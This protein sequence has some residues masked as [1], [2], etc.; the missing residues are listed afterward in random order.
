MQP[1]GQSSGDTATKLGLRAG[2]Y[3]QEIGY[4]EDVDFDLR[5]AI[6]AITGEE[7]ADE[8][9]DDEFDVIIMWWRADDPDLTDGLV[10][11][12]GTL[13]EGGRLWL[14]TPKAKRPGHISPADISE[15]APTAGMHV[16]KTISVASDWSGFCLVGKKNYG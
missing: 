11:A 16:T 15:A 10:D 3:I 4:D 7:M 2:Q 1:S 8:D 12:Q 13:A 14:L 9:V 6:E 5:E